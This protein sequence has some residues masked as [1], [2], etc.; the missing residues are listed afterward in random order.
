VG[1]KRNLTVQLAQKR[2][3]TVPQRGGLRWAREA[4]LDPW[5]IPRRDLPKGVPA[6]ELQATVA[7]HSDAETAEATTR[8]ENVSSKLKGQ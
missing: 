6:V 3:S 8:N 4:W 2:T 7:Q 1:R 5:T